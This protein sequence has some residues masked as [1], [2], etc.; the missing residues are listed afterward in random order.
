MSKTERP[1]RG[2][3]EGLQMAVVRGDELLGEINDR[4]IEEG[5]VLPLQSCGCNAD[6]R[7]APTSIPISNHVTSGPASPAF[8]D[9]SS[10]TIGNDLTPLQD[11]FP[12][13]PPSSVLP[14]AQASPY[15]FY[16]QQAFPRAPTS[17][18]STFP[19][20]LDQSDAT[21]RSR[22]DYFEAD[23]NSSRNMFDDSSTYRSTPASSSFSGQSPKL[24]DL[25]LPGTDL[26]APPVEYLENPPKQSDTTY[27]P[28]G[29]ED[30]YGDEMDAD[31]DIEEIIRQPQSS[32]EQWVM[33]LPSPSPSDSSSSSDG[34]LDLLNTLYRQPDLP[35]GSPEMLMLRFDKQTCGILSVK[36]G[37]TENPWRTLIWPLARESPALYHA[38]ASMTAFHT[39]KERPALRIEGVEH[40]RQSIGSLAGN[41]AN[42]P[43][44][45]ALATT[46]ALAFSES[47]DQHISTG[48]EHLR[49]AKILVDQA[50]VKHKRQNL[51]G[52]ELARMKFLVNTWVYMDVIARL[53]SVDTD[54]SNDFDNVVISYGPFTG[55][56]EVDPLMGCASSLFPVIGRVANLVRR[57]RRSD[58]NSP[59]II[60]TAMDLKSQL[61]QWS[62]DIFFDAPEDPTSDIEHSLQTAEAYRWATLLYLHQAVPEIPSLSSS[63]LAKK[64]LVYLATVPLSSRAIIVHIY[65]L[66]AAGCEAV[67]Q[68]DRQWVQE[69]WSTMTSR[70]WIGNIDRCWEVVKE[71][72]DR[73][74]AFDAEKSA[75]ESAL[76]EAF[77]PERLS[78][79]DTLSKRKLSAEEM[80][81]SDLFNWSEV[82]QDAFAA[83]KRRAA[84]GDSGVPKA[85]CLPNSGGRSPLESQNDDMDYERTVRGSV[86][87][88]GVMKD[89]N[90]EILLG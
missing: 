8:S 45:T 67:G 81:P 36:D 13:L 49:G 79:L 78:P 9:M 15:A 41:I 89:W 68:E 10:S 33:R 42:M 19:S 21:Q 60:S 72:W 73:R 26:N 24:S 25:L 11:M 30:I 63:E 86:H 84:S 56:S 35:A 75:R 55:S 39:S 28:S 82:T 61:E 66:L 22:E 12:P 50:L 48:I 1:L 76:N 37:P 20:Q 88:V 85:L 43:T 18:P 65:P 44:D 47:W 38:I 3:Q 58:G 2:L 32:A 59:S 51:V 70:M 53:T 87:W 80:S 16:G 27:Q 83:G 69:R 90:W 4:Q 23:T 7:T 62:A 71:V 54:E 40:M 74:D 17:A 29:L 57:V 5:R 6:R 77:S 52:E 46:L 14:P 64:V 31:E 34:R